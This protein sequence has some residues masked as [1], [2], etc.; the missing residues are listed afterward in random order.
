MHILLICRYGKTHSLHTRL[1]K[2]DSTSK[3]VDLTKIIINAWN[4][5]HTLHPFTINTPMKTPKPH[6]EKIRYSY[7]FPFIFF[8]SLFFP[9]ICLSRSLLFPLIL[10]YIIILGS[11]FFRNPRFL[12]YLLDQ[13]VLL[14]SCHSNKKL[15]I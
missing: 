4:T 3:F 1:V 10:F 13:R 15:R 5:L 14:H 12:L 9:L 7:L 2:K 6:C 8:S 11:F